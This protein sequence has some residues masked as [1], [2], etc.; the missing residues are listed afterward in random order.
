[1]LISGDWDA[2]RCKMFVGT[3]TGTT[4]QWF[5]GIHDGVINSFQTFSQIFVERFATNKVKPPQ[6][7]D[8]FDIKQQEGELLKSYPNRF[9]DISVR[10]HQPN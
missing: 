3:F 8:L 7:V 1:M 6:I 10:I 2:I 9:Y 4:L 5:S